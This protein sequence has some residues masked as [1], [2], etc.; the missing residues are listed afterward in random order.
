MSKVASRRLVIVVRA[1]PVICGHSVEARNLAEAALG[2]GFDEVRIVTWPI[3]RLIEAGL[4]MKPL[5]A[6]LPYSPGIIVERPDPVGDHRVPDGRFLA[7][8]TGRLVELFTDGVP[9]VALSLYLSPHALAVAEARRIALGTGLPV[10]VTTIAEAVGSD[11]TNIVR[12]SVA[13]GRLGAAAQVLGAYLDHD[14][15]VAVSEFTRE[16]II[17]SAEQIDAILGTRYA[18]Q[19]RRRIAVSY[20]AIDVASY[21]ELDPTATEAV[22][23][24][25]GLRPGR[26]AL[27]LSRLSR[28]KGVEDLIDG[29]AVSRARAERRAGDR[30]QRAGLPAVPGPGRRVRSRGQDHLLGRR[31]RRGEVATAGRGGGVHPAQQAQAGLHRDLRHRTWWRRCSPAADR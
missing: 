9:T 30:R 6:V 22:L 16:L 15:C 5:D 27:F 26:Y 3:D 23:S 28:A 8:L 17:A 7:G 12:S 20:P 13:C 25:R 19:C 31:R 4:P 2:Q 14:H 11:I 29:F 10:P 1:D 24:R 18:E 21:L